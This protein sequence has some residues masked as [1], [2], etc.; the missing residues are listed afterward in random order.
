METYKCLALCQKVDALEVYLPHSNCQIVFHAV[1][2]LPQLDHKMLGIKRFRIMF[3]DFTHFSSDD[4]TVVSNGDIV[5]SPLLLL[6]FTIFLKQSQ[7]AWKEWHK[8][9]YAVEH[10]ELDKIL[11]THDRIEVCSVLSAEFP[12]LAVSIHCGTHLIENQFAKD[13]GGFVFRVT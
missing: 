7:S 8:Y 12:A 4:K 6:S 5:V 9:F 10:F 11:L 1:N 3:L 13:L 2:N